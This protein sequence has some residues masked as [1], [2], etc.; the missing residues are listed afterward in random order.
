MVDPTKSFYY[1]WLCLISLAVLYNVL[2]IIGR[3]VF[4]RLQNAC[5]M[6]WFFLDYTCDLLYIVDMLVNA[7]TGYLEQ[8]LIVRDTHK[9]LINYLKGWQLKLDLLS[10]M[11]TDLF[12]L[13]IGTSCDQTIPCPVIVRLNRLLKCYRMFEFFDRTETRVS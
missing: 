8:G 3:S 11:P 13:V 10:L 7:R 4:W 6:V 1:H 2:L 12:Y 9:L 5:P